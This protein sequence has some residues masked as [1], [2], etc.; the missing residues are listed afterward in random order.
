MSTRDVKEQR[1]QSLMTKCAF[2]QVRM[3]PRDME[4]QKKRSRMQCRYLSDEKIYENF[5]TLPTILAIMQEKCENRQTKKNV[6]VE[7]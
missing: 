3:P 1:K 6:I 7:F 5:S 2:L 4:E